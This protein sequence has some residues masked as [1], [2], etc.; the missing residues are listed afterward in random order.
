MAIWATLMP[1]GSPSSRKI[2]I[3]RGFIRG[4]YHRLLN[5][6]NSSLSASPEP[7][8]APDIVEAI[9]DGR[10]PECMTLPGLLKGVPVVWDGQAA[11][12]LASGARL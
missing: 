11:S 12:L 1:F 8:L 7:L 3:D 10:Q 2:L 9:L 4:A 5:G 6:R